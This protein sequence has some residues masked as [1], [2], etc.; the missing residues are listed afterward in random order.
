MIEFDNVYLETSLMTRVLG[1]IFL[2]V[3]LFTYKSLLLKCKDENKK[4]LPIVIANWVIVGMV[5]LSGI[6]LIITSFHVK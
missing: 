4:D 6:G 5:S 2:L 1:C 3:I